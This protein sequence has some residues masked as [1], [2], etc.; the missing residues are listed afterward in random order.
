M[1]SARELMKDRKDPLRLKRMMTCR[2]VRVARPSAERPLTLCAPFLLE[3]IDFIA[4]LCG[5]LK[6]EILCGPT[7]FFFELCK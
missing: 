7:H 1:K 3:A 4:K 5:P 2:R 6:F